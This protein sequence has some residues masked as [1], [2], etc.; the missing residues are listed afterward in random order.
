MLI[1][2]A[3][4]IHLGASPDLGESWG[5]N[6]KQ[7]LWD[8][9]EK[10]IERVEEEQA[11]LLLIAGD[12]FHRQP[13]LRELREVNGLFSTLTKTKVVLIA[14]NH[15]FVGENSEY[16]ASIDDFKTFELYYGIHLKENGNVIN[17]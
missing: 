13:L 5:E 17:I 7:E 6:R 10:F 11:D 3:A 2:H 14:G 12:L 9:F 1:I 4:D 8:S 16:Y 15:D